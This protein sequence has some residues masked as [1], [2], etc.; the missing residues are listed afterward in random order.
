MKTN[1]QF[2]IIMAFLGY[3]MCS[4]GNVYENTNSVNNFSKDNTILVAEPVITVKG[5]LITIANGDTTPS[6][7]DNT[8][9]PS[10]QVVGETKSVTY[11]IS[12][13]G[14]SSF[15]I[16]SVQVSG[17]HSGDFG[18]VS[19]P[20]TTVL[21]GGQTFFTIAFNPIS[22]GLRSAVIEVV[23]DSPSN[24][25]YTFTVQGIGQ[26]FVECSYA[27]L[28]E[29]FVQQNF[30]SSSAFPVWDYS[31]TS[32][33]VSVSGG[34]AYAEY[35][36]P[37][38]L[39]D[40]FADTTSLQVKN[41]TTVVT[42]DP[43]NTSNLKDV[44]FTASL[45]SYATDTS[46]GSDASDSVTVAVSTNGGLSWSDEIQVKGSTNA[47]WSLLSGEGIA[48]STYTNTGVAEVFE[49]LGSDYR[50]EDGYATVVLDGLP[51]VAD[52]RIR[53][54]IVNDDTEEM[55]VVDD[56]T[57]TGK[58]QEATTWNGTSWSLGT[59][60]SSKKAVINGDYDTTMDGNI[61]ANSI[62]VNSGTKLTVTPNH[63]V[64]SQTNVMN[65]G[66]LTIEDGGA[67]NQVDDY[68]VNTGNITYKRNT[69]PVRRYDFTYWS[70]P[71]GNQTLYDLSPAT[72]S[73]KYYSFNP[74]TGNWEIQP[75]GTTTME[76]GKGY[77]VRAPN[78]FD[79]S[80]PAIFSTNFYGT[81]NNGVVSVPI[82]LQNGQTF[83]WNLIGNPYPSAIRVDDFLSLSEN[84]PLF[85]QTVYLWTH[86]SE[87]NSSNGYQYTTDDYAIYNFTGGV[88]AKAAYGVGQSS[89]TE[90]TP[91]GYI[92]SGQ[93]FF[94]KA[95]ANG[96]AVFNNSVRNISYN[97]EFYKNAITTA[98]PQMNIEKN[99]V[100][101]DIRNSQGAF[102]QTLVGYVTGATNDIDSKFDGI[103]LNGNSY[104]NFYSINA[105]SK[106]SIQGRALPFTTTDRVELGYYSAI[107][108][109]YKIS[110][111]HLDGVFEDP[112]IYIYLED[113]L[114]DVVYDLKA[115][116][117]SFTSAS[118]T[119]D[120]RFVLRYSNNALTNNQVAVTDNAIKV[121]TQ[122][123]KIIVQSLDNAIQEIAVH[124]ILGQ[125][126]F[127]QTAINQ[128]VFEI[129]K[130]NKSNQVYFLTIRCADG[131][132]VF[133]KIMF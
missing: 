36:S 66:T 50:V 59:P 127:T 121:V 123:N 73:D 79:L 128:T 111:N 49:P 85:D 57:L 18:V 78:N 114:L 3:E 37:A 62:Q 52:L 22:V 89:I 115:N 120:N 42:F 88:S 99:R 19:M 103:N 25:V 20:A 112:N 119:F 91:S 14:A 76:A 4:Y 15:D 65:F 125:E 48:A 130:I 10:T 64:N 2:M 54:T 132:E 5:N 56:V 33:S 21:S 75:Y 46:N 108:G 70:S 47:K 58:P 53:L 82:S 24:L 43:V 17:S 16:A 107:A 83:G 68:A 11:M 32:G 86:N 101:L 113:K 74:Q 97:A 40:A 72:L 13:D 77:I 26:S 29:V 90:I 126:I 84:E 116:P 98:L 12:N 63:F 109:T 6:A 87:L 105:A 92:A 60:N 23:L 44:T 7:I 61:E 9:F 1:L 118:G 34:T 39:V 117:Y 131:T 81:I 69:Q 80:V 122:S 55:W 51:S 95:K 100:W 93:S 96:T 8:I 71:V 28:N 133:K 106:F 94:I 110:I 27:T 124:D 35:G 104:M 102:K 45:G 67:L 31:V 129:N 41:A 30:E 38:S